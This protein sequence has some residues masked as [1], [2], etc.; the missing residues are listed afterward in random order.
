MLSTVQL[1]LTIIAPQYKSTTK[2]DSPKKKWKHL[3]L[4]SCAII[5]R[6]VRRTIR[7]K[8]SHDHSSTRRCRSTLNS[9]GCASTNDQTD[10]FCPPEIETVGMRDARP[11]RRRA[12]LGLATQMHSASQ[13]DQSCLSRC[14]WETL[15]RVASR[16]TRGAHAGS[17]WPPIAMTSARTI[18]IVPLLQQLCAHDEH[19]EP[20][21]RS[22]RKHKDE[23][24]DANEKRLLN[25]CPLR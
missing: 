4:A 21:R 1:L 6:L 5:T 19:H 10:S 3:Y 23:G 8:H 16:A 18:T 14:H 15:E 20:R 13:R 24:D 9:L 22:L 17:H 11:V 7:V 12:P 25:F 2:T